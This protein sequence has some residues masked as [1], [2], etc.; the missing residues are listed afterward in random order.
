MSSTIRWPGVMARALKLSAVAKDGYAPGPRAGK[1]YRRLV[2]MSVS[3]D[4]V[5]WEKPWRI[6][7]PDARDDGLLEFYG[8]GAIHFRGSLSIGLVR[9]LRDDLPCDPGGP[10]NGIGYSVL[11]SSRD[12]VS[13]HRYR[14]SFLNRNLEKKSWDHAMTWIGFALP[15]GDEMF[16]YYGGY[17]R[18]HK[19]EPGTERQ[20]GLARMKKDRYVAVR[21]IR[22]EGTLLTRPFDLSSDRLTLNADAAQGEIRVRI[23]GVDGKPVPGVERAESEPIRGDALAAEVRWPIS[24]SRALNRPV[25][26]SSNCDARHSLDLSFMSR[27]EGE[28]SRRTLLAWRPRQG[29]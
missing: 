27:N 14:E 21:P 20:I 18:G 5:H 16:F 6:F 7:A 13:W 8:M 25:R 10:S 12:G 29:K 3:Q 23:L 24:L 19:I 28:Q 22:D 9:V 2:G 11:A 17:A 1:A 26:W 15:V 4:F